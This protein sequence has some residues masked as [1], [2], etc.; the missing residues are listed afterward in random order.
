MSNVGG[1]IVTVIPAK[2]MVLITIEYIGEEIASLRN[3]S[4]KRMFPIFLPALMSG[5]GKPRK[6]PKLIVTPGYTGSLSESA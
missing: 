1:P 4:R 3:I 2:G 6:L 5:V